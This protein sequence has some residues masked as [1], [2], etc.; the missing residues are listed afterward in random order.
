MTEHLEQMSQK[1]AIGYGLEAMGEGGERRIEGEKA[2]G[3]WQR[4]KLLPAAQV[5]R[6]GRAGKRSASRLLALRPG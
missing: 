6:M 3:R 2:E 1:Q 5:F 4:R